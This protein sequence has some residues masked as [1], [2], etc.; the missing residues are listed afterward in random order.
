MTRFYDEDSLKEMHDEVIEQDL[1]KDKL[2]SLEQELKS[3]NKELQGKSTYFQKLY[4]DRTNG[5]LPEKEFLILLNKY[6]DDN[7]KLEERSSIIKKEIASTIAKKE[8]LKSKK[9][10]FK[11]YKHID[12]LD[13]EIV[14]DFIDKVLIGRYDDE[15]ESREIKVLWNFTI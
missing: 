3:I 1:F 9:N 8:S 6:K 13:I 12:K 4:E 2:N 15:T 11:K 5:I 14:G 10:I 7:S